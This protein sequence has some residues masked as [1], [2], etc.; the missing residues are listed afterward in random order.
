MR[1]LDAGAGALRV[2]P[3]GERADLF[4]AVGMLR[5]NQWSYGQKDVSRFVQVTAEEA[6]NRSSL[7]LSLVAIDESEQAIGVVGLGDVDD[8]VSDAERRGRTPWI[9]GMVVA[10][11]RRQQGVGRRLFEGLH[12]AA[13]TLSHDRT[14]VATG[15]QAVNFYKSCGSSAVETLELRSTGISTTILVKDTR[16]Q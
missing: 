5:W 6:G 4:G 9:L 2:E 13:A 7:P 12:Q 16:S 1:A 11:D 8:E 15:V 14:W 10:S 3:L